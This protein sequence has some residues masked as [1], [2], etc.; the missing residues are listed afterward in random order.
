MPELN[1]ERLQPCLFDRLIDENPGSQKDTRAERAISI[2]RY[3]EG[4]LRDLGWLL[5]SKA[6]LETEDINL[7]GETARSVVNYGIPD[8]CGRLASGLDMREIER[9]IVQAVERF[10]Q[11]IIPNTVTV[12]AVEG[13]E[14][15]GP[16]MIAFEIRGELWANPV[17]EQLY[18]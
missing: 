13:G 11:R 1:D 2:K 3:R 14:K 9:R 4:V 17:S 12:K 18:I 8:L 15:I 16:N 6:H 5:N 10:E 7:F